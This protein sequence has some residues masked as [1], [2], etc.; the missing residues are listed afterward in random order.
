MTE[1]EIK[2]LREGNEKKESRS[3]HEGRLHSV[4]TACALRLIAYIM[5]LI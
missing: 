2:G 5:E 1:N 4:V 3:G